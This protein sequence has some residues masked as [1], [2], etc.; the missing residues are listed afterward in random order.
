[1]APP[2]F[3]IGP[4]FGAPKTG[5]LQADPS[6]W[7]L[8][9]DSPPVSPIVGLG[10]WL[11]M[12]AKQRIWTHDSH[13][14]TSLPPDVFDDLD[15]YHYHVVTA[16]SVHFGQP[17]HQQVR[18]IFPSPQYLVVECNRRNVYTRNTLRPEHM[19]DV[20]VFRRGGLRGNPGIID[21]DSEPP[22]DFEGEFE[23]DS[24]GDFEGAR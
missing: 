14:V 4:S 22:S 7:F 17:D 13:P 3:I 20:W 12:T 10:P 21:F 16:R 9:T 23:G 8:K 24:E 18:D 15:L 11:R 2:P 19:V 5:Y 6:A 1:M